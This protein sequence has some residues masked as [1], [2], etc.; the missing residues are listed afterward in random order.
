LIQASISAEHL[1]CR[2]VAAAAAWNL[3]DEFVVIGGG[4]PLP[5]PG[6][7]DRTYPFRSH[8]EYFYLT[9]CERPGGVLAFDP[10]EGWLEFLAPV[11]R[12]EL[13]WSGTEDAEEGVPDGAYDVSELPRWLEERHGRRCGCLGAAVPGVSSDARVEDDLR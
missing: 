11:T 6:R 4:E 1:S 8:S 12:N 9:D 13:V 5:V 3:T 7:Y 2:R 10:N